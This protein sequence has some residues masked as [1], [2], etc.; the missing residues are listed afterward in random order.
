MSQSNLARRALLPGLALA[1]WAP[2]IVRASS[3][4][5]ISPWP[6]EPA[7]HAGFVERLRFSWC[8]HALKRWLAGAPLPAIHVIGGTGP[9]SLTVKEVA[10][11]VAYA[12]RHGFLQ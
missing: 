11:T 5:A 6:W 10:R 12:R 1:I 4:M 7:P 2:A 3:L 8:D 9:H